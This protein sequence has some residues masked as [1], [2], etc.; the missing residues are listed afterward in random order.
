MFVPNIEKHN[1]II[2]ATLNE[3]NEKLE[4]YGKVGVIRPTG[5]GKTYSVST[6]LKDA[7]RYIFLEPTNNIITDIT[8]KYP[9][10]NPYNIITLSKLYNDFKS[11]GFDKEKIP[12]QYFD[13]EYIIIDEVHRSGALKLQVAINKLIEFNPQAKLIGIS[14][15]EY[16][17][18]SRSMIEEIFKNIRVFEYSLSDAIKDGI[19][20]EP[21]YK[22][23]NM[24]DDK[25][26][27]E[28]EI[29]LSLISAKRYTDQTIKFIIYH[30]NS[31]YINKFKYMVEKWFNN[32]YP[33]KEIISYIITSKNT[34]NQNDKT[35]IDFSTSEDPDKIYICHSINIMN[36]GVHDIKQLTGAIMLRKTNS[37]IIYDQQF[38]RCFEY[39]MTK[40]PVLLDFVG[41]INHRYEFDK[42]KF[43]IN[44]DNPV[45]K[46]YRSYYGKESSEH[47]I[48]IRS[49][50][51]TKSYDCD[52]LI[53]RLGKIINVDEMKNN[54]FYDYTKYHLSIY[55]LSIKYNIS[56][57][58]IYFWLLNE[59]LLKKINI[60]DKFINIIIIERHR[61]GIRV[62]ELA[63]ELNVDENIIWRLIHINKSNRRKNNI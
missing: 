21:E 18:D 4:T 14:A 8:Y 60:N 16:R 11:A 19:F 47:E 54:V 17:M 23:I 33:G 13:L 53:N 7:E 37:H 40:I 28:S 2:Q 43:N 38:G 48:K 32:I 59:D 44:P 3:M 30:K 50:S 51:D 36:E 29:K 5:F 27:I 57:R 1:E 25:T 6:L 20:P 58:T 24:D 22:T 31:K 55:D 12:E 62:K 26:D 34:K 61:H 41:N 9:Y 45:D 46:D 49:N 35:L 15:N 39:G 56:Y 10:L 52:Q 42:S 63:Q